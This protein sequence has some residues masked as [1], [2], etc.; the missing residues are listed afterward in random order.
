M[1]ERGVAG[2]ITKGC[3]TAIRSLSVRTRAVITGCSGCRAASHLCRGS[4]GFIGD[5]TGKAGCRQGQ[6]DENQ[7]NSA[8]IVV[9]ACDVHG[10]PEKHNLNFCKVL[11]YNFKF[12]VVR[13]D[14]RRLEIT[15]CY[16]SKA[17]RKRDAFD[18]SLEISGI[19]PEWL[20]HVSSKAHASST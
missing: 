11:R 5:G 18:R 6:I 2:A 9:C 19:L 4:A 8:D 20:V 12:M 1:T 7:D 14:K 16:K 10:L 3:I 17:I 15:G 13:S